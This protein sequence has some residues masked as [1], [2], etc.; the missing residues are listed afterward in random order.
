MHAL[1][2][3][4]VTGCRSCG[5]DFALRR[6]FLNERR[7]DGGRWTCPYCGSCISYGADS[8][9]S[10]LKRE[11]QRERRFKESAELARDKARADRDHAENRRRAE[12]AAKTRIKNR[13]A[14]GVCPCCNRTFQN[15][16]QHM[17][18]QH[19]EFASID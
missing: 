10:K 4:E 6:D 15:L 16:G 5:L 3:L 13:I 11:L 12:K 1:V 14:K 19:P 2:K 18:L 7:T 17:S 9:N 8:E